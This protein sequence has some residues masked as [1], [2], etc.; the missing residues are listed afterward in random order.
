MLSEHL[1]LDGGD[2][3]YQEPTLE[4]EVLHYPGEIAKFHIMAFM[5]GEET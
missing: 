4:N 1:T 5:K 2:Y 3:L